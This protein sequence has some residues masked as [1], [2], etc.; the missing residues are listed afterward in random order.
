MLGLNISLTKILSRW[1]KNNFQTITYNGKLSQS[2][3]S[4]KVRIY[5]H[6]KLNA[7]VSLPSDPD[8]AVKELTHVHLK[9]YV[10]LN[11]LKANFSVLNFLCYERKVGK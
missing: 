5:E 8:S 4:T 9:R 10:C 11:A 1:A 3:L 2:Y 7:S 6:Y